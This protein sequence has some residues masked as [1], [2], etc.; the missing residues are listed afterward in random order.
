MG[1]AYTQLFPPKPEFTEQNIPSLEGKVF[2]ITG[3]NSGIGFEIAKILYSRGG[4]VYIA[5]RSLAKI[6]AAIDTIKSAAQP[7]SG[8]LKSL[9][10]DTSDLTT[11][12]PC[13]SKFL[14]Q[15]SRLDVLFNN[16]GVR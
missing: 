2:I 7:K 10:L 6:D 3:G 15:E 5:G 11:V 8:S 16:A 14:A 1:A 12:S 13:V 9:L 4:T